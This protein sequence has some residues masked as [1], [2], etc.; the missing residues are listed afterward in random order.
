MKMDDLAKSNVLQK[1][2]DM[3]DDDIKEKMKK[4]KHGVVSISMTV[5]KPSNDRLQ[6]LRKRLMGEEEDED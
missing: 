4:K 3:M 6:G 5:A 1:I 2:I